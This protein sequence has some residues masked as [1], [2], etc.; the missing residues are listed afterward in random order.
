M[1][2]GNNVYL[3]IAGVLTMVIFASVMTNLIENEPVASAVGGIEATLTLTTTEPPQP[4]NITYNLTEV[5]EEV[6][7]EAK[8]YFEGIDFYDFKII[9][10]A[11]AGWLES[12]YSD[13]EKTIWIG[14]IGTEDNESLYKLVFAHEY[15]HYL[16]HRLGLS[17]NN[18]HEGLADVYTWFTNKEASKEVW[19]DKNQN[20]K[21]P[22]TLISTKLIAENKEICLNDVFDKN[23][24]IDN[25]DDI[26]LRLNKYCEIEMVYIFNNI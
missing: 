19:G 13:E 25:F 14:L 10:D 20:R 23:N 9:N 6:I 5:Q 4:K 3:V 22:Y 7:A 1:K 21:F 16:L 15:E 12:A 17:N 2:K 26:I 11:N 18:A 8:E 24:K